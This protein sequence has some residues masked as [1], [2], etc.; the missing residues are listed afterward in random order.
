MLNQIGLQLL[1]GSL[2]NVGVQQADVAD[3]GRLLVQLADVIRL[4]VA[5]GVREDAFSFGLAVD[6]VD[7]KAVFKC[8]S[9]IKV[10][11]VTPL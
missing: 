10:S 7:V 11:I 3:A 6:K 1:F 2:L 5:R 9:S 4:Q 8:D